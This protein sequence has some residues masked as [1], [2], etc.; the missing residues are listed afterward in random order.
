MKIKNILDRLE[1]IPSELEQ[2]EVE[3]ADVEQAEVEQPEVA[4]YNLGDFVKFNDGEF[5]LIACIEAM[6]EEKL[7]VRIQAIHG[8]EFEATDDVRVVEA[9]SVMGYNS[10]GED[11]PA[12]AVSEGD[13]VKFYC[14]EGEIKARVVSVTDCVTVE[15]YMLVDGG[16]EPTGVLI[17]RKANE[18][19]AIAPLPEASEKKLLVCLNEIKMDYTQEKSIGVI[20][21][22]ASTYGNVDLGGDVVTKGAFTQTLR[23]KGGKVPLLL[24]HS[25]TSKDVAGVAYLTDDEKGLK[26]NGEMPLGIKSIAETY[27]KI[28]FLADRGIKMGLSIGYDTIKSTT[29][30]DGIRNLKELALHEVSITPFPM[31][32]QSMIMSAKSRRIGYHAKREVWQTNIDAPKGSQEQEGATALLGELKSIIQSLRK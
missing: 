24:D 4:T 19:T 28:K 14:P 17:E 22:Y 10:S 3:Q 9:S 27:E 8:N 30:P 12:P 5:E 26:L 1:E 20:E 21:G 15:P 32:T 7:T 25:Y 6:E 31:N 29:S 18:L 2:T 11:I 23:H 13:F 16:Y